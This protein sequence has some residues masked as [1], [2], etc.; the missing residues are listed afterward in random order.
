MDIAMIGL[1]KLGLPVSCAIT[2]RGH[3]VYGYD[4]DDSLRD[5]IRAG[6]CP[7]YE[8][9]ADGMVQDALLSGLH[10]VDTVEEAVTPANIIFIAVPTPSRGDHSFETSYVEDVLIALAPYIGE[11]QPYRVV[12]VISTV[13]PGTCRNVFLPTLETELGYP[14]GPSYGFCYAAQFIAM[15]TVVRDF[16]HPEFALVGEYDQRSGDVLGAFYSSCVDAPILRM[17]LESAEAVKMCYNTYIGSKIVIANTIMELCHR[18]PGADCD[19]VSNALQLATKRITGPTYM[20]G[21][22]GDSGPCHPRDQ[23]ALSFLA[24]QLNLSAD[25]FAFVMEA[26]DAQSRWLARLVE[27][28]VDRTGFPVAVLGTTFKPNTNLTVDSAPLLLVDHLNELALTV[29]TYDPIVGP[30][31]LPYQPYVYVLA[32]RHDSLRYYPF[33]PGSV[34]IDPWRMLSTAPDGCKWVP[35]GGS[36]LEGE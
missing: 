4:I 16:L 33:C 35:I 1:G 17:S 28:E 13:L 14:P 24:S 11:G 31:H 34:V 36:P 2:Q 6:D 3:T 10:V 19:V 32:M 29:E 21:G 27:A 7:Y 20:V 15:G 5:R 12:A 23:R 9:D 26:R 8:P 25:P 30:Y 22:M 18:V